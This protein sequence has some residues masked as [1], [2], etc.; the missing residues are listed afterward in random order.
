MKSHR[1]VSYKSV[2]YKKECNDFFKFSKNEVT[3][4]YQKFITEV[5]FCV[6]LV[7][8]WVDIVGKRLPRARC[9]EKG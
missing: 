8:N 7:F 6:Y 5:Y 3:K 9:L 2:A 4:M 1:V